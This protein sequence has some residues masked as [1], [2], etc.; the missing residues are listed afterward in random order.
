MIWIW[1]PVEESISI[2]SPS[3]SSNM[4][5]ASSAQAFESRPLEDFLVQM[6]QLKKMGPLNNLIGL[7]PGM[8]KEIR[9]VEI[10]DKQVNQIEAIIRSMTAEERANPDV[11]DASRRARIATGSGTN[12][13]QVSGLVTQFSEMRKMMKRFG[14]MGTKKARK[15][16]RGKKKKGG[17]GRKGGGGRVTPKG[18]GRHQSG[19]VTP[20]GTKAGKAPLMLPGLDRLDEAELEKMAKDLEGFDL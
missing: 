3:G 19:R 7:M 5:F 11:I 20:K 17:K 12:P 4:M 1:S 13:T 9:D 2:R 6:Q 18:G 8:P 16:R 15:D 14:G 10:E